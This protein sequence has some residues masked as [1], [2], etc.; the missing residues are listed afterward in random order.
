MCTKKMF[1]LRTLLFRFCLC[2]LAASLTGCA[3]IKIVHIPIPIPTFGLG[4]REKPQAPATAREPSDRQLLATGET[5]G[6][7]SWYGE[8]LNGRRTASGERFNMNAMTAA[9]RTLP[10]D[11]RVRVTN[12]ENGKKCV[13]RINDRGPFVE[14][15]VIDVSRAAARRLDFVNQG[16]T[17]VQLEL[18]E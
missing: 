15:R 18:L 9:H 3:G 2:L 7:A 4:G 17:Q 13:V 11:T 10:F 5:S 8:N 14:N 1:Y 6:Q 16:I 12:V